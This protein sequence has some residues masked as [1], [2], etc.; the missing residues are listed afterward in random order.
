M[1]VFI[2]S[3]WTVSYMQNYKKYI[4]FDSDFSWIIQY[5]HIYVHLEANA[6]I[7][8]NIFGTVEEYDSDRKMTKIA[9]KNVIT[10]T[11]NISKT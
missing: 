2:I 7:L 10:Y 5:V 1:L 6:K 4:W 3:F 8:K 11:N 9:Q